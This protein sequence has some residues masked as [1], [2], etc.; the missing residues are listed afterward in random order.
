MY[1]LGHILG[2]FTQ[3]VERERLCS[4]IVGTESHPVTTY[5]AP[6]IPCKQADPSHLSQALHSFCDLMGKKGVV[7][8]T[9]IRS[10][11]RR[12]GEGRGA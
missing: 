10:H 9:H 3:I 11:D 8:Y 5:S 6:H 1:E 12:C 4:A 2:I 7:G